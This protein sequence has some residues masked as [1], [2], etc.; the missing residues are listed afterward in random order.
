MNC[1]DSQEGFLD[2]ETSENYV[3]LK[4]IRTSWTVRKNVVLMI[5]I[6]WLKKLI[7]DTKVTGPRIYVEILPT[8]V[9]TSCEDICLHEG[10][11]VPKVLS[12]LCEEVACPLEESGR[13]QGEAGGNQI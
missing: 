12:P 1:K 4:K 9:D 7:V 5:V 2:D 6:K 13:P 10:G 3:H 11:R 8:F